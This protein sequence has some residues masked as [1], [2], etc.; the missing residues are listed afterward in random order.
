[1]K[2]DAKYW[3]QAERVGRQIFHSIGNI[4]VD[5]HAGPAYFAGMWLSRQ[6]FW[7]RLAIALSV[8]PHGRQHNCIDFGCGFG[9]LLPLLRQ[10]F[11]QVIGVDLH[12]E[13]PQQFVD[14]WDADAPTPVEGGRLSIV[15][16]LTQCNLAPGSVDLIV[17]LDV[18]EHIAPLDELLQQ[19]NALLT[20]DGV[21]L[22]SGPSETWFYRLGRRM[23]GFSGEY[24]VSTVYD[25]ERNLQKIFRTQRVRRWPPIPVLFEFLL[26]TKLNTHA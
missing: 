19:I 18:L 22:I 15:S 23:V 4:D 24:H 16:N 13:L 10:N 7:H 3:R 21:L 2:A 26:A 17:A 9:L 25:V 20:D 6:V 11:Q 14:L 8:I 12:P 5:E 1:M